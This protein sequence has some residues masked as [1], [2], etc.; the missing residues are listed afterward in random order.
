MTSRLLKTGRPPT[1][2]WFFWIAAVLALALAGGFAWRSGFAQPNPQDIA[3]LLRRAADA[4]DTEARTRLAEWADRKLP[5]A[6]IAYA[7]LLLH[8]RDATIRPRALPYLESAANQGNAVAARQL[9]DLLQVGGAN[10]P[11]DSAA[12]RRWYRLAAEHGNAEAA[13][14]LALFSLDGPSTPE[15]LA[16][17]RR[18]LTE[19]ARQHDGHAMFL[20]GNLQLSGKG[21]PPDTAGALKWY[22][23]AAAEGF[24]PALETLALAYERGDL[25][26]APDPMQA[27]LMRQEAAEALLNH[28]HQ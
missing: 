18:W 25:G 8:D 4:R 23:A 12:A 2:Q 11:A 27:R 5:T 15:A 17:A 20:L 19:A 28:A 6:Q 22:E 9:G 1:R 21:Q 14:K 3:T 16:E 24:I 7:Q 10:I 26:L 13:R